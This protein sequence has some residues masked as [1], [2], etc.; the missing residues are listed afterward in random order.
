MDHALEELSGKAGEQKDLAIGLA[1]G[2]N[3]GQ[4]LPFVASIL[5]H[6]TCEVETVYAH[7][8]DTFAALSLREASE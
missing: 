5:K 7:R 4:M 2:L 6:A 1:V 8:Q 3:G